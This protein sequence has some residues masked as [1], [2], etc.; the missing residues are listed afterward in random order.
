MLR[1]RSVLKAVLLGSVASWAMNSNAFASSCGDHI[2]RIAGVFAPDTMN[3]FA[4]WASFWPTCM[5]YDCLVGVDAQRHSDRKGFAKDWSVAKDE[6]TWTI[7][8]WPDMKWSDGQPATARDAAFTY[9]YL[10]GSLGK[11]D[12]LN[13]GWNNTSGL[14]NISSVEAVDDLT[15]KIVTEGPTRWPVDNVIL[16]VPEHVWKNV[17]YADARGN[18]QN[19]PPLVG[20]GP[21]IVEEFQ[22]GQFV[23]FSPNRY[24]RTGQPATAGMIMRFFNTADPIAQGLKSGELDYGLG[25]TAAQSADLS[26]NPDM[27]VG[28]SPVEQRDYLAFNTLSGKGAGTTKAI[29]DPAFRDAIAYAINQKVIVDRAYRGN[30]QLGVGLA[31]PAASDFYSDLTDIRRGFDVA[32]AARRLDAAGYRDADGDGVREDKEGKSFQIELITGTFSGVLEIP[33]AAVQLIVGWLGQI[34][35]P[36]SVTQ[37]DAGALSARTTAPDSGGG[38]WDM[39]VAS[40]WRSPTPHDLLSLGSSRQIGSANVAY[41]T[42]EKFDEL[43]AEIDVTVDLKKSQQLVDQAARL[44]YTEAPYVMLA[45]PFVLDA[46]RTD[47]FKG[48]GEQDMMSMWGYFPFDRLGSI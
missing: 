18:F 2:V 20:T 37:L 6:T 23:R 29:Q 35:I 3:P 4:T 34:G 10:I 39:V 33:I 11:P 47:C 14:E 17:S 19:V 16:I 38:N 25:L 40:G 43:L 41:W 8:I 44:I 26:K 21:M 45:Y 30:A 15:L 7:N 22:Q 1:R 31:M 28:R 24:F 12:E 46:R 36:V 5:T 13:V 27:I 32:E 48:W 42:N 9:N